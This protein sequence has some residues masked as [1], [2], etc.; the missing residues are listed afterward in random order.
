[1]AKDLWCDI[2][3]EKIILHARQLNVFAYILTKCRFRYLESVPA[4][5]QETSLIPFEE[6]VHLT[7]QEV[8]C[9]WFLNYP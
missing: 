7:M 3:A 1:M 2:M 8:H 4:H 6:L 9:L 5:N